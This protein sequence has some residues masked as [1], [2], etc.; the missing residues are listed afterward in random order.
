M[1]PHRPQIG[2]GT[3]TPPPNQGS[4]G[5]KRQFDWDQ[6]FDKICPP[7]A[8]SI[9]VGI[10]RDPNNHRFIDIA[11]RREITDDELRALHEYLRGWKPQ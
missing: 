11:L 4:A 6:P 3:P 9:V 1:K 2:T 8:Q 5:N 7:S 10:G